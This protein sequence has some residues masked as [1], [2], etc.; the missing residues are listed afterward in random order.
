MRVEWSCSRGNCE[1]TATSVPPPVCAAL[2]DI[3]L[4][5]L[6]EGA[7]AVVCGASVVSGALV[8]HEATCRPV[9]CVGAADCPQWDDRLYSC[10][11][12][13]CATDSRAPDLLDVTAACLANVDRPATCAALSTDPETQAAL[14]TALAA[15]TAA[16]CAIPETCAP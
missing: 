6:G 4:F 13:W 3:D 9:R 16:S 8:L 5:V 14:M 15:C 1:A 2:P 11:L 10:V 12:G 7:L